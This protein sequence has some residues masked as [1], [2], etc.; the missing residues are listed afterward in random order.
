MNYTFADLLN[1]FFRLHQDTLQRKTQD[2]LAN[3]LKIS[4]RTVVGWFAG[5]Y[6]PRSPEL[7]EKLARLLCLTAFQAD[8]LLYSV[9]PE[10]V[11]YGTPLAV[12]EAAEI[13]RYREEE[14]EYTKQAVKTVPAIAQI[15]REWSLVFEE[16]FATNY[17]R[18]GVGVKSNNIGRIERTIQDQRY[19]L[20]LEN[21]YHED[22]FMGGDSNCLAPP[23]YYATVTAEM[24]Q[25]ETEADGYAI[26]FEEINDECNAMFRVREKL[27]RASVVQTFDGSD[28]Y[29][30]YLKQVAAPSLR[31]KEKNKLAI[32]AIHEDH[33]FYLNDALVGEHVIPRLPRA[34]LDVGIIAGIQQ[35]VVCHFYNFCVYVPPAT[36][37]YPNLTNLIEMPL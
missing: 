23:I 28:K 3:E 35:Q 20:T 36:K 10:W 7:V 31:P 11:K 13:L 9:K 12:L 27:R 33:W 5:D 32:L 37:V 19:V 29:N 25:G 22:V 17:Q 26:F 30:V 24:R 21:Q 16:R 4:K 34:R 2:D 18:W 15:E 14:I 6:A 8:L 1:I